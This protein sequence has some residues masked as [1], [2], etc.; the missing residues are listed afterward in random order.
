MFGS[1]VSGGASGKSWL[2]V[3]TAISESLFRILANNH[4]TMYVTTMPAK[5]APTIAPACKPFRQSSTS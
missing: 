3:L 1:G 5:E 4:K 2:V